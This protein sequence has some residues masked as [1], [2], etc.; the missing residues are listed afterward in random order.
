MKVQKII[1]HCSAT[2]EGANIKASDIKQWHVK[3]NGWSDIGY[4]YVIEL[5]GTIKKGRPENVAGAHC[6]GQNSVALGICYVGGVDKNGKAKDT[7]TEAQRHS[8]F[9]LVHD[10]LQ[11][12]NL[13]LNDVYCHNDFAKK[14]C[15]SFKKETFVH[16]YKSH[17]CIK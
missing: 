16:E 7:R 9:H 3:D 11:R 2:K 10:L 14:D 15:P 4:H 5:D 12:Y 8:L 6:T 1:L 13:T 17:Y